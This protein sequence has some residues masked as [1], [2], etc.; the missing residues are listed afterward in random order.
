[1]SSLHVILKSYNKG[2]YSSYSIKAYENPVYT[3][4]G[5]RSQVLASSSTQTNEAL[6]ATLTLAKR[7]RH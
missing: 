5:T 6:L 4:P 3:P 7:V 1:M 2:Y